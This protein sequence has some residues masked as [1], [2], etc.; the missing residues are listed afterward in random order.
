MFLKVNDEIVAP[1]DE[2]YGLG[3]RASLGYTSRQRGS[4]NNHRCLI[5]AVLL[6]CGLFFRFYILLTQFSVCSVFAHV[7]ACVCDSVS[8]FFPLPYS[9]Q[10]L[11]V[12]VM[13]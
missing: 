8:F 5:Q 3:R 7:R 10:L 4:D 1:A 13:T 9:F 11:K 12:V 2:K 6:C